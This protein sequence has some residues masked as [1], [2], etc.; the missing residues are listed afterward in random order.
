M[1][2]LREWLSL[3]NIVQKLDLRIYCPFG[4][5]LT[6]WYFMIARSDRISVYFGACAE[7]VLIVLG[8]F[9]RV[10]CCPNEVVY[11]DTDST[12]R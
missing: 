7:E 3:L 5:N 1:R 12:I 8:I 10:I 6:L 4:Y 2:K 11:W 9:M